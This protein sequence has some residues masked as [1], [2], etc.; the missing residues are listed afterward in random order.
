MNDKIVPDERR[1]ENRTDEELVAAAVNGD[2]DC[3]AELINRYV[4][5]IRKRAMTFSGGLPDD[6]AQEGLMGLLGAVQSYD[7]SKE[8]DFSAYAMICVRNRM[9]SAY[10]KQ[11]SGVETV[12]QEQAEDTHDPADIPENIVLQREE[13]NDLLSVIGS[14]LSQLELRV[15][16]AYVSGASYDQ[17]AKKLDISR[18]AVDNAMQRV[19][20]K[21]KDS[22]E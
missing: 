9:I 21:L 1:P 20:R 4:G 7:S 17:I 12:P 15:F 14:R 13:L 6:L 16:R 22:L 8:V 11:N 19:R 5:I 10:R 2:R 3:A 18:K